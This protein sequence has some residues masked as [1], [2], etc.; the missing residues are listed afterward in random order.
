MKLGTICPC[1]GCTSRHIACHS[2]CEGYK[3]FKE[4]READLKAD[5]EQKYEKAAY[6]RRV[7][8]RAERYNG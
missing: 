4:K 5:R 3:Q 6:V 2:D 8:D 7:I 1:K